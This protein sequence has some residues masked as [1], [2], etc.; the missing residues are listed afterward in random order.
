MIKKESRFISLGELLQKEGDSEKARLYLS[1][2]LTLAQT[3]K[4]PWLT[5]HALIHWGE[6]LLFGRLR[7][8]QEQ[9]E[10][11]VAFEQA[12]RI[13]RELG[14]AELERRALEGMREAGSLLENL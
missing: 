13:A 7:A 1:E 3:I 12:L 2:A 5:S 9:K 8:Q 10:A 6:F 14:A 11:L 4:H